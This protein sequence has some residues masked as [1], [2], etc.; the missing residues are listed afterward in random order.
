M[1]N[2]VNLYHPEFHPKLR[3][4]TLSFVVLSW[5]FAALICGLLYFYVASEQQDFKSEIAKIE[6]NKQQQTIL[7]NELQSAV[8]NIKVDP[9]L[10]KQVQK[11]QQLIALKNRVLNELAGQEELKSIGFSNLMLDLAS[12]HHKGLW[13][14]HINL[15]GISVVMEGAATDSAIVPKWLSSLGQ[16]DYFRGQEFANTRLY[17][18]SD[19]QLNFV[20]STGKELIA[21]Q[22]ANND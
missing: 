7:V 10:L 3:L 5:A 14:T 6:Q 17:R 9:K 18:D 13:L 19:Q 2:R 11:N 12:H 16:T 15:D 4:L 1:K 21:E 8:D 20:I 22:G